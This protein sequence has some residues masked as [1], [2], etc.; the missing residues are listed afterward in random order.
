[1]I[2]RRVV[3]G[4]R[5]RLERALEPVRSYRRE[6]RKPRPDVPIV[7]RLSLLRDFIP[8]HRSQGRS[9]LEDGRPWITF[10]A[11]R[12]LEHGLPAGA[13]VFEYGSGG[14][15]LFLGR[16]AAQVV[17]VE[18]DPSWFAE[19]RAAVAS[20]PAVEVVLALPRPATTEA[21]AAVASAS[22]DFAGQTFLDYVAVADRFPDHHFDLL[23]VDGRARP[24][25][26]FRGEPKVRIGGLVLLDDSERARYGTVVEAAAAAGW[27]ERG[28]YGPKAFTPWF[29]RTTVWTKTR[30]LDP[31]GT[32]LPTSA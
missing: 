7:G 24:S 9:T 13:K 26:F 15:T 31:G 2:V 23:I 10:E 14:S 19:V 25:A 16:R 5:R 27:V 17:S 21:E 11:V 12:I 6:I 8:W 20:L 18:H 29:A 1:V 3:R 4:L 22:P 32:Q 28:R 30:D